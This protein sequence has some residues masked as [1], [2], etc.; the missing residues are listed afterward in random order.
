M[1]TEIRI[2][3]PCR[4]AGLMSALILSACGGGGVDGQEIGKAYA[5]GLTEGVACAFANCKESPDLALSDISAKFY[6]TQKDGLV[7]VS[8][9]LGQSA[10]LVTT[11]RPAGADKITATVNGQNLNLADDSKGL[12]L[13]YSGQMNENSA[14]PVVTVSFQRG[15]DSYPATVTLQPEFSLTS[16]ASPLNLPR[17]AGVMTVQFNRSLSGTVSAAFNASCQ[18]TDNTSFTASSSIPYSVVSDTYQVSTAE[19]DKALTILSRAANN[20]KPDTPLVTTC[21]LD[22]SWNNE[23]TGIVS[24]AL[25]RYSNIYGTRSAKHRVSYDATK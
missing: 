23:V 21:I 16:P 2:S 13:H 24:N 25:N 4:I 14:Q 1:Q 8:A 3:A 5:D 17:G 15:N 7:Q 19:L 11:V 12:R 6:V 22:F 18:R 10:N 9:S 20:Q